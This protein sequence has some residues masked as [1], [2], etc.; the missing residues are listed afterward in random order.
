MKDH[1]LVGPIVLCPSSVKKYKQFMKSY[2]VQVLTLIGLTLSLPSLV[3]HLNKSPQR[4][5]DNILQSLWTWIITTYPDIVN[6]YLFGSVCA[7]TTFFISCLYFSWK[8]L[9]RHESK[10]QKDWWPSLYDMI[11]TGVPQM[12][13]YCG[14]NYLFWVLKPIRIELPEE[15]PSIYEF[16][17]D[18]MIMLIVGDYYIYFEHRTMHNFPILRDNI[19]SVHHVY[20]KVFSWAGGYVHP[21]EDLAAVLT[22][23]ACP[24]FF[25]KPHPFTFWVFV[26]FWTLCLVDEH[27]GHD[28]WW[29]PYKW[30]PFSVGGGGAPHDIHHYKPH[31]N[32]GFVFCVWDLLFFTFEDVTDWYPGKTDFEPW[33][34][35]PENL[36]PVEGILKKDM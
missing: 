6:H 15:A 19:H 29:S 14:L 17:R 4:N 22:Q 21:L 2:K 13:I 1:T 26:S 33:A 18:F 36:I 8:D 24:V 20:K 30:L 16:C 10:I 31:T 32:F 12:A 27:S 34:G 28:V 5:K 3:G 11:V 23:V 35:A 7:M 9:A 25:L